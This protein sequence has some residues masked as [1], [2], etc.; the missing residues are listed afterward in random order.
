M[1]Q[2]DPWLDRTVAEVVRRFPDTM[3]AL[4]R[5]GIDLCYGDRPTLRQAAEQV[6]VKPDA[7]LAALAAA[8]HGREGRDR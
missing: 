8:E 1:E 4:H 2:R 6:G 5:L 7:L 3:P